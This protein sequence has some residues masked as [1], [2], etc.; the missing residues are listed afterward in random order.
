VPGRRS[1]MGGRGRR[2]ICAYDRPTTILQSDRP[3]R[4]DAVPQPHRAADSVAELGALLR[5]ARAA[6]PLRPTLP[7][8][9]LGL[10]AEPESPYI[11]CSDFGPPRSGP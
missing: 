5:V 7:L 9:V 11:S 6:R 2:R 8:V 1:A 10:L 4:S 3:G